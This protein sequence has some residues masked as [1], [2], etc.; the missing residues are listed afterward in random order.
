MH[1]YHRIITI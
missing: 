1:P